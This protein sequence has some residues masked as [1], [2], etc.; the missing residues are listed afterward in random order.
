[1]ESS[2]KQPELALYADR[3]A[4]FAHWPREKAQRPRDLAIAGLFYMGQGDHTKCFHCGGSLH[5][6]EPRDDPWTE[7]AR[8]YPNC[9]YLIASKGSAF[10]SAARQGQEQ[11]LPE[12]TPESYV[13]TRASLTNSSQAS[14]T[15]TSSWH[16]SGIEGMKH[17]SLTFFSVRFY[18]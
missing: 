11:V 10:I 5:R 15:G 9:E 8:V 16:S 3:L 18:A 1:M 12:S 13:L 7:H 6:W 14:S 2:P 4:T 17:L